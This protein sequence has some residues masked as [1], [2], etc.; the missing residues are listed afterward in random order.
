MTSKL[1]TNNTNTPTAET[2]EAALTTRYKDDLATS[3]PQGIEPTGYA[4][5][6]CGLLNAS[7]DVLTCT[8]E[9]LLTSILA[10]ARTGL[11]PASGGFYF[12][13]Y[14]DQCQFLLSYKGMVQLARDAGA[15]VDC[16][17]R[18]VHEGDAFEWSQGASE[19]I[20]HQP[21]LDPTRTTAPITHVY[22]VAVLPCGRQLFECWDRGR[23][24][25]HVA[26][27]VKGA[28]SKASPW[29]KDF[30]AMAKKTLITQ[31]FSSGRL[32]M[33]STVTGA[34]GDEATTP[35]ETETV[36]PS[37]SV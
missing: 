16:Y 10:A 31:V 1:M 9:S 33:S 30:E 23:L 20:T 34:A 18:I 17:A 6:M 15:I 11:E 5:A 8:K 7:R 12:V 24:D 28:S 27:H 4:K 32:P 35:T 13:K 26:N 29:Q 2:I 37:E 14:G 3:L 25:A 36:E 19:T 22:A 21:S